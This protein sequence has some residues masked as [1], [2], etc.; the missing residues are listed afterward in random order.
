MPVVLV[1]LWLGAG[2]FGSGNRGDKDTTARVGE[3]HT[4][5]PAPSVGGGFGGMLP[6]LHDACCH[7]VFLSPQLLL[8]L[9]LSFFLSTGLLAGDFFP[10]A[11]VRPR[12]LW[13]GWRE[14]KRLHTATDS[15]GASV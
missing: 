5:A 7:G 14:G 6:P 13:R 15:K 10:R 2:A 4:E 1:V 8:S 9:S 12:P 11:R 3:Q